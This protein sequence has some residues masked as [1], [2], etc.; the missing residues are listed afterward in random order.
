MLYLLTNY[1]VDPTYSSKILQTVIATI[2]YLIILFA[3]NDFF[4]NNFL[5]NNMFTIAFVIIIDLIYFFINIK[6]TKKNIDK[7]L[8]VPEYDYSMNLSEDDI[9]V[10]HSSDEKQE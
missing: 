6:R 3:M 7:T 9:K 4:G 2:I 5:K 8:F 10:T 1:F